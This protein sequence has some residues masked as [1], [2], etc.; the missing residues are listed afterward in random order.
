M[1]SNI[2]S[3]AKWRIYFLVLKIVSYLIST[4]KFNNITSKFNL[5]IKKTRLILSKQ[6][7]EFIFIV[8]QN[9]DKF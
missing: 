1:N 2:L 5:N 3:I 6:T 9:S 8:K 4:N 7:T